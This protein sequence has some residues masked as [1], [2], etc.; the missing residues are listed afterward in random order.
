MN[1][2]L[3]FSYTNLIAIVGAIIFIVVVKKKVSSG[4]ISQEP[5]TMK[6]RI[7]VLIL[8]I[9][10]PVWSGFIFYFGWRKQLP[11]KA[12]SS[13]R[14]S[15]IVFIPWLVFYLLVGAIKY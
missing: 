3:I 1:W 12:K 10:N 13:N 14:I 7:F 9:L 4:Q 6:E 2:T 15:Y 11:L 5:L 8:N